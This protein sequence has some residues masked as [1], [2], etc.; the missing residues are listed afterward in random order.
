MDFPISRIDELLSGMLDGMLSEAE[1]VELDREMAKNPSLEVRLD[2]LTAIRRSLMSGRSTKNLSPDFARSVTIAAM[3]RADELAARAS[4][5]DASEESG[6][7]LE[8]TFGPKLSVPTADAGRL[9]VWLSA[10]ALSICALVLVFLF[11]SPTPERQGIVFV[12][13]LNEP[14]L[15]QPATKVPD[16]IPDPAKDVFAQSGSDLPVQKDVKVPAVSGAKV[17]DIAPSVKANRTAEFGTTEKTLKDPN[18]TEAIAG[19]PRLLRSP[20]QVL[21]DNP[22]ESPTE[23]PAATKKLFLLAIMDIS[24]D[25]QAVENRVLERILE[26]YGI[27]YTDDL[28]LNDM[29]V[30]TLSNSRWVGNPANSKTTEEVERMGVLFLRSTAN[31]LGSAVAE[32]VQ[33]LADFPE[34][35]MSMVDGGE[36][37]KLLVDQL[38]EIQ[39]AESPNGFA[40]RLQIPSARGNPAPFIASSSLANPM[41]KS[42][43]KDYKGPVAYMLPDHEVMSN[44]LIL[45]R[46]A[47]K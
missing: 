34:C 27:V 4:K 36:S 25:P 42:V 38:S 16:I 7:P 46:P 45:L 47:K 35:T 28:V 6:I 26:K 33:N 21:V 39:V 20:T 11:A 12:P 24:L 1:Y 43:R 10:S 5:R 14:S 23:K 9:R 18:S 13:D 2:E 30:E 17:A 19:Q 3:K 44:Y 22:T 8:E 31:K 41:S 32:I 15:E 29:Q 37:A 40:G